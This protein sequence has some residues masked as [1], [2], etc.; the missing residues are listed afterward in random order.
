ML[1]DDFQES[2]IEISPSGDKILFS[3]ERTGREELW[4]YN[5]NTEIYTQVTDEQLYGKNAT[6]YNVIWKDNNTISTYIRFNE[7]WGFGDF[8]V[9]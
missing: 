5:M 9:E 4:V 3:S 7:V 8:E 1:E 6:W 2:F